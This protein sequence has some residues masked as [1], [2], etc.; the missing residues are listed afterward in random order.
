MSNAL[1]LEAFKEE[2]IDGKVYYMSPSVNPK[3]GRVIGNIY[4]VFKS[5]LRGKKCQVF[6]DTIDVY[7]D[8]EKKDKVIPDVSILCDE[9]KFTDKGIPQL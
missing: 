6:T 2:F 4:F 7:L 9:T 8:A 3:Y 5:Y 1:D